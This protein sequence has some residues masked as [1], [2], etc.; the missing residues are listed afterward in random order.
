VN[1]NP[2]RPNCAWRQIQSASGSDPG[3]LPE[4]GASRSTGEPGPGRKQIEHN[5]YGSP[6]A[7]AQGGELGNRSSVGGSAEGSELEDVAGDERPAVCAG[8]D[9]ARAARPLNTRRK[10]EEGDL[11]LI[12]RRQP[13]SASGLRASERDVFWRRTKAQGNK[14][15]PHQNYSIVENSPHSRNNIAHEYDMTTL[16]QT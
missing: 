13:R 8:E 3:S 6:R 4:P 7:G 9:A 14:E 1:R 10:R 15:R 2:R 12:R 16:Y 11:I 5:P